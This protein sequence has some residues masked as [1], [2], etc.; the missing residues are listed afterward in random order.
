MKRISYDKINLLYNE[1]SQIT[2]LYLP[3]KESGAVNFKKFDE[4]QTPDI[5]TLQTV[6]SAKDLFFPQ[7][8]D[9]V[10]FKTDGRNI[11]I[12]DARI[13][14]DSFVVFGVR[15]CDMRSFEILDKVFLTEPVD[16]MYQNKRDAGI[17]FTLACNNP[18][19]SCFCKV[20]GIDAS[21]PQGDVECRVV[22]GFL[23]LDAKTEK[24]KLV[25][26]EELLASLK[27]KLSAVK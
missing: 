23:Y 10:K 6:K 20:F 25:K 2:E 22:D 26:N 9:M 4:T 5:E 16:T 7:S 17:I 1:L 24:E 21:K 12:T 11:K 15:A 18:Q 27:E 3:V 19:P 13:I 14:K 8:E